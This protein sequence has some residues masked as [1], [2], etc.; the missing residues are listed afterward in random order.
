MKVMEFEGRHIYAHYVHL[1]A[2]NG[3]IIQV[4]VSDTELSAV[5]V[6]K[7]SRPLFPPVVCG[8]LSP[9]REGRWKLVGRVPVEKFIYPIF[10][11]GTGSRGVEPRWW[12][13]DGIR[14]QKVESVPPELRSCEVLVVWSASLPEERI[15]TGK[16]LFGYE[17][18]MQWAKE[19][20]PP[21]PRREPPSV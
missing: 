6:P 14:E 15:R 13:Y 9:V 18:M 10:R 4:Y 16:N 8:I 17:A 12:I 21:R 5:E 7:Q 19:P 3:P 1:D 2:S 20:P 11:M